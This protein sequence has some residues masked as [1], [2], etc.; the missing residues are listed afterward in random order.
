MGS[1]AWPE[2][3][4]HDPVAMAN[5]GTIMGDFAQDQLSILIDNEIAAVMNLVPIHLDLEFSDLPDRGVDWAVEKAVADFEAS[6]RPNAL[7]GL[8]VVVKR[9]FR[10]RNLSET[11]TQ[12]I[13]EHAA[14][15]GCEHVLLPVRPS[16]KHEFPLIPMEQYI[17]WRNKEDLPF[18]GWLRVHEK[19]G[20]ETI[21]VCHQSMIIPG[22]VAEWEAWTGQRFPDTG[23]YIVPFALNPI[24]I[25]VERD[26]GQYVEPNVWVVHKV[27]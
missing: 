23:A 24:E 25:D 7:V 3:M 1:S 17:T 26:L 19:L 11:A 18:D 12:A 2:F 8:Q 4:V 22:T 13:V 16:N 27:G 21:G 20:G 14:Q 15:R 5:W 10:G 6:V 9:S